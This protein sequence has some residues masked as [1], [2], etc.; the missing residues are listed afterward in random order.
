M[1]NWG[2]SMAE[3]GK[4][5]AEVNADLFLQTVRARKAGTYLVPPWLALLTNLSS[6]RRAGLS[7]KRSC[8][9]GGQKKSRN[10]TSSRTATG[11]RGNQ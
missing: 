9:W 8:F 5:G 3:R 6:S 2:S 4:E 7:A 1:G 11:R 10:Q